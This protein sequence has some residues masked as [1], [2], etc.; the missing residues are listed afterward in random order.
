MGAKPVQS[1]NSSKQTQADII[2][3]QTLLHK[4]IL[5]PASSIKV[6]SGLVRI[7]ANINL[8]DE[9][10]WSPLHLA[11]KEN[12]VELAKVLIRMARIKR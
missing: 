6:L 8:I 9:N 10:G 1:Q 4:F 7:G 5:S 11:L 2:N 3:E 12:K